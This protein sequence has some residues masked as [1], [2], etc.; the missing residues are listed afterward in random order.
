MKGQG[1][2]FLTIVAP[3]KWENLPVAAECRTEG[4]TEHRTVEVSECRVVRTT[5]AK[6]G[7]R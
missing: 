4:A 1:G 5:A 2:Q 7:L 6:T 3:R